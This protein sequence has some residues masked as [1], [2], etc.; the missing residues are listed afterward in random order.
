MLLRQVG[1]T[2]ASWWF[3]WRTTGRQWI[4]FGGDLA[5]GFVGSYELLVTAGMFGERFTWL[6]WRDIIIDPGPARTRV[7]VL[8]ACTPVPLPLSAVVC[9]HFH[10]E[11]IGNAAAVA[12]AHGVPVYGSELTLAAV[13]QPPACRWSSLKPICRPCRRICK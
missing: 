6:R 4:F 11:H 8:A 2:L 10:E 9:T 1:I 12:A 13:R 7:V 3:A 5:I